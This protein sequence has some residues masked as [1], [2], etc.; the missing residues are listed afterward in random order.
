M[1]TH[2]SPPIV[3]LKHK[4]Q[5][6]NANHMPGDNCFDVVRI[7]IRDAR[8]DFEIGEMARVPRGRG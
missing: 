4:L 2:V 5:T 3:P 6:V 7:K 8:G 1:H